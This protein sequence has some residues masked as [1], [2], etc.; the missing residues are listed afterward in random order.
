MGLKIKNTTICTKVCA[1]GNSQTV[2][3]RHNLD[4]IFSNMKSER[5]I[6]S[7]QSGDRSNPTRMV[8]EGFTLLRV[9]E[10]RQTSK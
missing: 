10:V 4:V 3:S 7:H 8:N 5:C 9:I 2:R 1:S 6:M